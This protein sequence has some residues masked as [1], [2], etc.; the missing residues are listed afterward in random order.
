MYIHGHL[1]D[2]AVRILFS[3]LLKSFLGNLRRLWLRRG[4]GLRRIRP[5]AVASG[6]TNLKRCLAFPF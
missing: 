6:P 2:R 4:S 1:K 3:K 5:V